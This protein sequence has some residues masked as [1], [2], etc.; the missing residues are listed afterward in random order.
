MKLTE[1]DLMDKITKVE[2]DIVNVTT[3]KGREVLAMYLEYL[4]DELADLRKES[5]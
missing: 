4:K 5:K 2:N 1:Q 3:E